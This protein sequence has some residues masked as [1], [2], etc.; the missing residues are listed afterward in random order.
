MSRLKAKTKLSKTAVAE[1]QYPDDN[2]VAAQ[3]SRDLQI[4]L[5]AFHYAY[6]KLG[7][8]INVKKT[9][10]LFQP[11]PKDNTP[12]DI[13]IGESTLVN[14]D[15][16][17]YLGSIVSADADIT[18]EV[19]QRIEQAATAFGKLKNR[20]F[21]DSDIR[22]DTKSKAYKAIIIPTLLYASETWTT[23]HRHLKALEKFHQRYLRN[24]MNI[25]WQDK[26][27]NLSVLEQVNTD[28]I[29]SLIV[30]NQLIGQVILSGWRI[31][32]CQNRYF[33]QNWQR[34]RETEGDRRKGIRIT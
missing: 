30:K 31:H 21:S 19:H 1:F 7:L 9:Q 20:V 32:N 22:L 12:P 29:E 26:K 13:K 27:A 5:H 18:A 11:A 33:T 15:K 10:I 34:E 8:K 23:Y 28:S 16:F 17:S 24:I 2:G 14:V 25:K 3:S 4:I 6:S